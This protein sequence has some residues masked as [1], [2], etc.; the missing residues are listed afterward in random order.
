MTQQG[1]SATET[2]NS[3]RW[4]MSEEIS[5]EHLEQ[6]QVNAVLTAVVQGMNQTEL[7]VEVRLSAVKALYN[8]LYFADS[9]FANEMERNYILKVICETAV[10][11]EV[12]IR[13][14]AF[15]C[16]VAIASIY[17]MH[18]EPYMQTV[19]NLT[20]N[21]VKGD[22][23]SVALQAI[24]FWSTIC[25]EEIQLQE[26]YEGYD[27]ANSSA[28]FRFIEKALSSLVPMLL[29]TLLKQEEDEEQDDNVWNISMSGG[30]CLGLIAKAVGDAIVPL[31]MP[32]VEANI[33]N[34]DWHCR[35]AATFAFGSILDGPSL[36][37][38]APLWESDCNKWKPSAYHDSI[39]GSSKDVPN[40]AEKVCG[41]IYFLAQGYENTVDSI[42]S[43]LTPYL[44]SVITALLSA[45]TV[46][47]RPISNRS[48]AYRR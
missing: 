24:E 21:T 8:A 30:T 27:D 4:G 17:Y 12:E 41:A 32:F 34:P 40:V 36:P 11:N 42:S 7:S 20:S 13:Q 5:P 29:E 19:F 31:V 28:N 16:L 25:D 15:E 44:P 46:L 35:E 26:E 47:T 38:L 23:E 22:E 6:D 14:A 3:R 33:T 18:L 45:W 37:K 2:S 1:A 9:N 39:A 43:V 10:S 48:S